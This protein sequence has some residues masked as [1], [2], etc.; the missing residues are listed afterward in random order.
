M[1]VKYVSWIQKSYFT[2]V[3]SSSQQ[4]SIFYWYQNFFRGENSS[5][6]VR[7][8]FLALGCIFTHNNATYQTIGTNAV[9]LASTWHLVQK[10]PWA[11]L[12]T[13][14]LITIF[15]LIHDCK[16][17]LF[18]I[19]ITM[20]IYMNQLSARA[21]IS[22]SAPGLIRTKHLLAWP[23]IKVKNLARVRNAPAYKKQI[24]G[25]DR[26]KAKCSVWERPV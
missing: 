9:F 19:Y 5:I 24:N 3:F 2:A 7:D 10:C 4:S 22:R 25:P 14:F 13:S 6:L 18:Q 1:L 23:D 16:T 8:C 12:W 11:A 17:C 26:Y 20:N 15:Y 21:I